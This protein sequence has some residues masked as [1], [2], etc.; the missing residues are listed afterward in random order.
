MNDPKNLFIRINVRDVPNLA[1]FI[2]DAQS[3]NEIIKLYRLYQ[4]NLQ[5]IY[6]SEGEE[7]E[8][9]E[10]TDYIIDLRYLTLSLVWQ[11]VDP[12]GMIGM[13][14]HIRYTQRDFTN[15]LEKIFR[16]GIPYVDL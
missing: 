1:M 13:Y 15:I 2:V 4:S 7:R 12:S 8:F 3:R 6:S 11:E 9:Y 5:R 10:N 14:G 16:Q